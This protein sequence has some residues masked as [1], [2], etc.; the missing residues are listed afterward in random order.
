MLS[1]SSRWL[2]RHAFTLKWAAALGAGVALILLARLLSLEEPLAWLRGQIQVLGVAGPVVFVL[3][4]VFLTAVLLP[5]WPLNVLAGALFGPLWGGAIT[6]LA[7]TVAAAGP[8]LVA[9]YLV[10]EQVAG[11][12]RYYPRLG[13][14]YQALGTEANWKVV[15][16]VR[17][18]HALPYGLQNY[19]LGVTPV[20]L[21]P[22]LLTTWVVTLPGIFFIAYLGYVGAA[23]LGSEGSLESRWQWVARGLGV[24]VAAGAIYYIGRVVR[25]AVAEHGG[26]ALDEQNEDNSARSTAEGHVISP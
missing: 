3:A 25:R 15:A 4:F 5:G 24:L 6:S 8:F 23:A 18:S 1:R 11:C 20:R 26:P 16:A 12:F 19:L 10:R 17:L 9:R 2:R 22:F 14:V 7:S 13:A 21:W